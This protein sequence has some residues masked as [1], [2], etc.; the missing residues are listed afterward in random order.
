MY[1][2]PGSQSYF[3]K[4]TSQKIFLNKTKNIYMCRFYKILCLFLVLSENYLQLHC[5]RGNEIFYVNFIVTYFKLYKS[6]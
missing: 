2:T 5:T 1:L 3:K 4:I 6:P